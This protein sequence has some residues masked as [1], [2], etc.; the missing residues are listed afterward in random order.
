M[1]LT[2]TVK[3]ML[4][5]TWEVPPERVARSL[6]AG[7]E[8]ALVA[9][10]S[11]LVSIAAFRNEGVRLS[12]RRVPGFSQLNVRTYVTRAG[13]PA[14]FF[15]LLR[16]TPAGLGGV[17]AGVPYRPARIRA[18]EGIAE[19]PGVG[20]SIR[21]SRG[22]EPPSV[23]AFQTGP[24]GTHDVGY[25]VAAGLRRLVAHH[26]P[27]AWESAELRAIPR[28]DA[29]LALGFDGREPDS[30]LYASSTALTVELPP[31]KLA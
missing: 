24:L 4:L 28:L 14:V 10:G 7:L 12:G 25:F 19:A 27:F 17:L 20:V 13:E 22:G 26:D 8:P 11:A 2:L 29:L 23:P 31:E 5:A 1:R 15:L 30:L 21:Y 16:V 18:R 6:P 9:G 3:H